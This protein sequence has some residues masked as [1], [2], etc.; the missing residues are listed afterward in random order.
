MNTTIEHKIQSEIV[1]YFHNNFCLKHHNPRCVIFS[2]PNELA[3]SNKIAAARAKTT[4]LK[5]GVSDLI[6]VKYG[7]VIFVEVKNEKGRQSPVQKEFEEIITD[8]GFRYVLVRSL[9]EFKS[10]I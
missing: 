7:E 9:A 4:G 6:V 1:S 10:L 3:G 5:A 8:L 2:V